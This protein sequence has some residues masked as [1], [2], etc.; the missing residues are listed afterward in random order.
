MNNNDKSVEPRF[1]E[2]KTLAGFLGRQESFPQQVHHLSGTPPHTA[3][4]AVQYT[5]SVA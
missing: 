4:C 3:Y 2:E 1:E 5:F